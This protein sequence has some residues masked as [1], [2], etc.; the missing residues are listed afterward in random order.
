[1]K[2]AADYVA[3]NGTA[4]PD[5]SEFK[6]YTTLLQKIFL[7][8]LH[9][10]ASPNKTVALIERLDTDLGFGTKQNAELLYVWYQIT[11]EAGYTKNFDA[12][13]TLLGKVGRQKMIV[14]IY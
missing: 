5:F 10:H 12:I 6:N 1:L 3:L 2:L 7:E 14:P 13:D 9:S 11:I 8:S 4:S